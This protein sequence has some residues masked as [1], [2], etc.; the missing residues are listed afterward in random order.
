MP[1]SDDTILRGLKRQ[2]K[3]RR[4]AA[5]KG[6]PCAPDGEGRSCQRSWPAPNLIVGVAVVRA[7][8]RIS[9]VIKLFPRGAV[10]TTGAGSLLHWLKNNET[11]LSA[12]K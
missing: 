7:C 3:T 9:R 8:S 10:Q 11:Q 6:S 5:N 4:A 1:T 2:A 12:T